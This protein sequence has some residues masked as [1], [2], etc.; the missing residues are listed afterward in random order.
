M[1]VLDTQCFSQQLV[2]QIDDIAIV[3]VGEF[4][5]QPIARPA[6]LTMAYTVRKDQVVAVRVE[7]T[8]SIEECLRKG[9]A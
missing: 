3:V 1:E 7:R 8:T 9:R 6:G 4:R 5:F 2:L